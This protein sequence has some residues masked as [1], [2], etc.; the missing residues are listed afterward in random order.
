MK[1]ESINR[2]RGKKSRWIWI[3]ER[4]EWKKIVNEDKE[5][6]VRSIGGKKEKGRKSYGEG[7]WREIL[8]KV[9]EWKNGRMERVWEN[10]ERIKDEWIKKENR[11]DNWWR[12]WVKEEDY[13]KI[14]KWRYWKRR[15]LKKRRRKGKNR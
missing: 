13:G 10:E 14:G 4:E 1:K 7:V 15:D 12:W 9:V 2:R 6:Y 3:E 5:D 11:K 8:E